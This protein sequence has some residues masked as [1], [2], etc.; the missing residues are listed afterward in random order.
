MGTPPVG[1]VDWKNVHR[2]A[3]PT[4]ASK[5]S[6]INQ[7]F[8]LVLATFLADFSHGSYRRT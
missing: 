7:R 6:V 2:L 4:A 8:R 3:R 1:L 5:K